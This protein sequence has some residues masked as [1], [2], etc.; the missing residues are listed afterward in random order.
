MS[1]SSFTSCLVINRHTEYGNLR[2]SVRPRRGAALRLRGIYSASEHSESQVI[3]SRPQKGQVR[4][5]VVIGIQPAVQLSLD[6][7][8]EETTQH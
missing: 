7:L 2:E 5:S 1:I 4:T 6:E 8:L 3:A